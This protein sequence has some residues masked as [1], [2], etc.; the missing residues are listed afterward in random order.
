M[1]KATL[2]HVPFVYRFVFLWFEP[3]A[4]LGGALLLHFSP[5]TF[6]NTMSSAAK[7][8]PDNQVIYHQVAATYT[9]FAYN[10]AVI[11][12]VTSDLR[13]WR[14]VI[15]GILICDALHILA[16]YAAIGSVI[17]NVGEWRWE[18]W[19]NLGSLFGQAAVRVAFLAGVGLKGNIRVK[20]D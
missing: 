12:R 14:A 9:L 18:D 5:E 15:I 19:V 17:W 10:E 2:T 1:A 16:S 7:Y 4:A 3:F 6:L 20:S 13:V 11:L 8:A